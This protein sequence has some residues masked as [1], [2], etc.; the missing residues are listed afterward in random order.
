MV[1]NKQASSINSSSEGVGEGEM[2]SV[3]KGLLLA[4]VDQCQRLSS[5]EAVYDDG[6]GTSY[7]YADLNIHVRGMQFPEAVTQFSSN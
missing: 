6:R 5:N 2:V 1:D 4:L 3:D 7:N